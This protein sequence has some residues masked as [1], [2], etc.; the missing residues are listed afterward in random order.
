MSTVLIKKRPSPIAGIR[1]WKKVSANGEIAR[2]AP[3][4]IAL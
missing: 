4:S 2:P 3:F 1:R